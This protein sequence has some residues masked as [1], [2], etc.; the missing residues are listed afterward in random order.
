MRGSPSLGHE[1]LQAYHLPSRVV[2]IFYLATK[3]DLRPAPNEW[4]VCAPCALHNIYLPR[5]ITLRRRR[6]GMKWEMWG[7]TSE[8]LKRWG[9]H[10]RAP[11]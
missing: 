8:L 7:T 11:T 9:L 1:S 5:G 4:R 6:Q 3:H 2:Y 10:C